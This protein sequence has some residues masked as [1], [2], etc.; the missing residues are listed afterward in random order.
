MKRPHVKI[1]GNTNDSDAALVGANADYC[2]ILVEV[3]FSER[4]LTLDQACNVADASGTKNIILLCNP[5][6]ELG[7]QVADRIK[8]YAIQ[9]LCQESPEFLHKLKSTVSCQVWKTVHL[10]EIEGQ[11]P[12]AEYVDAG[13]D[14]LLVD[15]ADDSEGFLRMGGTGRTTDWSL[16]RDVVEKVDTPVYLAGGISPSNVI[17]AVRSVRPYGIDLC[18]GVEAEKGTKDPAKVA[19]LFDSLRSIEQEPAK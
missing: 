17:D 6:Q 7:K 9:L 4:S 3:G 18:S 14:A 11:A 16:A 13:A 12:Y 8:P 1:C 10:P 5:S 2:G 15:A 19:A